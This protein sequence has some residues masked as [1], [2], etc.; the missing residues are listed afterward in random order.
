MKKTGNKEEIIVYGE[1]SIQLLQ[2]IMDGISNKPLLTENYSIDFSRL[3]KLK[4]SI[5]KKFG[6]PY[7]KCKIKYEGKDDILIDRAEPAVRNIDK[8]E[9]HALKKRIAK[10][11]K[12]IGERLE[13]GSLPS[14]METELFCNNAR[15]MT[16]YPDH[17][18]SMYPVFLKLIDAFQDA[19]HQFDL[20]KCQSKFAEIKIMKKSCHQEAGRSD[21]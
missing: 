10:T 8:P 12:T 1:H 17:V 7:V 5:K 3:K 15:M 4:I 20:Q 13:S 9:Y 11:V 6:Q 18:D 19:F 21:A 2:H 16:T 14:N